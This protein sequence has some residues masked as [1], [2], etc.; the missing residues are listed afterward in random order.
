MFEMPQWKYKHRSLAGTV[1][2]HM[3][4]ESLGDDSCDRATVI[5]NHHR[6]GRDV[7]RELRRDLAIETVNDK[8]ILGQAMSAI[9]W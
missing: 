4:P 8:H 1:D 7:Q 2:S 5:P 6:Q 3:L 9:Q